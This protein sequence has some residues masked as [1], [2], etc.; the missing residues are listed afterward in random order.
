LV[1][2]S[3]FAVVGAA[4]V[5][6]GLADVVVVAG[7]SVLGVVVGIGAGGGLDQLVVQV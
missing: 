5:V 1:E 3:G 6:V 7:G 2:G 4:V